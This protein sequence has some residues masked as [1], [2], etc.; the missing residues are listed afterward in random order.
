MS[1]QNKCPK[2]DVVFRGTDILSPA[3]SR[4][5][6]E[7]RYVVIVVLQKHYQTLY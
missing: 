7:Q 3:I 4:R 1:K 5:D 2:C 6:N